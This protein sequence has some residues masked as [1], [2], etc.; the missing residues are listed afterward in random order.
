MAVAVSNGLVL[1]LGYASL[2]L[3]SFSGLAAE[4]TDVLPSHLEWAW[5]G[6]MQRACTMAAV[7]DKLGSARTVRGGLVDC[8]GVI[9]GSETG[10]RKGRTRERMMGLEV[11]PA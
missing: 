4:V 5:K 3:L 11:R 10:S 7:V 9:A 2:R 8:R 1:S 6:N